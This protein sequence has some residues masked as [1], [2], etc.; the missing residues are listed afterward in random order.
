MILGQ[1]PGLIFFGAGWVFLALPSYLFA[2]FDEEAT[3]KC[4]SGN[5]LSVGNWP[6]FPL[7][8]G[9]VGVLLMAAGYQA[10]RIPLLAMG[11]PALRSEAVDLSWR[12]VLGFHV[13]S[14]GTQRTVEEWAM[15]S[16]TIGFVGAG[17]SFGLTTFCAYNKGHDLVFWEECYQVDRGFSCAFG[18]YDHCLE[19]DISTNKFDEST[20]LP[21]SYFILL[22]LAVSTAILGPLGWFALW[23][24]VRQAVR[25]AHV[26]QKT[27]EGL[28]ELPQ[29][30]MFALAA[31]VGCISGIGAWVFR[32][33]IGAVHNIL[34]MQKTVL[35]GEYDE[36]YNPDNT[37]WPYSIFYYDA[38]AHTPPPYKFPQVAIILSP[39]LGGLVVAFLVTNWAPEA[40]G[41]G[42]PEV[43]DAIHYKQGKI[44]PLV[45]GTKIVA[46]SFSIGSGG[47]V[48][49][50]GPIIQIGSTCAQPSASLV[51]STLLP[52][53]E[54]DA[55]GCAVG[56]MVGMA[57]GCSIPQRITLIAC[58]G[59]G[60]IAA[61]FN[62]PIG[63]IVFAVEL[64]LPAANSRTVM[65]LGI[66][67]VVA[68][69]IGRAVRTP[70]PPLTSK[71]RG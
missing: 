45:A 46:S 48:G 7:L 28:K 11:G 5:C 38:N 67:S 19:D 62:T 33:M 8:A 10:L 17:W 9:L 13:H 42:V 36:V 61:T 1:L 43:M 70:D 29:T 40:K 44:R 22:M 68:T 59:A 53:A 24:V 30:A 57:S 31:A 58:G 49:R 26:K 2:G 34:F 66:T 35:S 21:H 12:G 60:G 23:K 6:A 3:K 37:S 25:P 71:A 56:S 15:V 14:E 69:Y 51:A 39:I 63:G 16:S 4:P 50:E 52:D 54:R 20:K 55:V 41:H 47:S 32:M 27:A 65:P 64:M 18:N